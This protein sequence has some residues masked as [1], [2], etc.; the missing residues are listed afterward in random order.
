[1][2]GFFSLIAI[3]LSCLGLF[4]LTAFLTS[5]RLKEIGIRKALGAQT[6]SVSVLLNKPFIKWILISSVFAFPIAY[7]ITTEWLQQFSYRTDMGFGV[8][9]LAP[10]LVIIIALATVS[11]LTV[12]A[13]RTNPIEILKYE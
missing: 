6:V 4:G 2:I 7:Y 12:K 3:G 5:R 8:F 1:M 11:Y 9:I 10:V 13:A